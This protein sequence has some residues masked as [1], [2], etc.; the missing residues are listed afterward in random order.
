MCSSRSPTPATTSV[1]AALRSVQAN[2]STGQAFSVSSSTAT[3]PIAALARPPPIA[4][5]SSARRSSALAIDQA[6]GRRRANSAQATK[7][8]TT[9]ATPK[10]SDSE[11]MVPDATLPATVAAISAAVFSRRRAG[12]RQES[13]SHRKA[14]PEAGHTSASWVPSRRVARPTMTASR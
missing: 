12:K 11:S 6:C 3:G 7:A 5:I 13:A 4:P 1:P 9:F 14:T 2:G 8:C 10:I